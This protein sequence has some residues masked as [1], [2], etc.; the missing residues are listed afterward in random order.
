MIVL[1]FHT[2]DHEKARQ[3]VQD[4][5]DVAVHARVC[6]RNGDLFTGY[7]ERT[8]GRDQVVAVHAPHH[9]EIVAAYAK[10]GIPA[11]EMPECGHGQE[12]D[13]APLVITEDAPTEPPAR[14][15]PRRGRVL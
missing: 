1:A 4:A 10:A 14:K 8:L 13:D 6:G 2:R 15:A 11:L 3:I 12:D 5:Q 7:I 9:P